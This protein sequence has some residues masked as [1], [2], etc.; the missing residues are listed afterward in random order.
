[1]SENYF[2]SLLRTN[3]FKPIWSTP[4]SILIHTSMSFKISEIIASFLYIVMRTP[5]NMDYM[6]FVNILESLV[7]MPKSL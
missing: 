7:T 6:G 5:P 1:M 4:H 2:Q 3:N